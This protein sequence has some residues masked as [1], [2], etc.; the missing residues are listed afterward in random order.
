MD[1]LHIEGPVQ[2]C[3]EITV[4]GSKNAA[5]PIMAA[6]LLAPGTSTITGVPHLSDIAV[7]QALLAELGCGAQ[8]NADGH[9]LI[10][11]SNITNPVGQ[12]DTVRRILAYPQRRESTG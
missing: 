5:L 7:F 12:Y 8:R 9:L 2:L 10:D 6:A 4:N 3:G 11:A 1:V